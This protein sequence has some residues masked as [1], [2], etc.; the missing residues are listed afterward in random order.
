MIFSFLKEFE[1]MKKITPGFIQLVCPVVLQTI[2]VEDAVR[3][4]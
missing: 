3:Y 4:G 1:F 2:I